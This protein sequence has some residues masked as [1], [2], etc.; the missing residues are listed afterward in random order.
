MKEFGDDYWI[1]LGQRAV[2]CEGW[3]WMPGMRA[4]HSYTGGVRVLATDDGE[5]SEEYVVLPD[6]G[7]NCVMRPFDWAVVGCFARK[8]GNEP[9][10]PDLRDPAT[11]GCLLALVR[12]AWGHE[13]EIEC[14]WYDGHLYRVVG[15]CPNGNARLD[16]WS[17]N[18]ADE[19][20]RHRAGV[21]VQAL[22]S[23]PS[24][25]AK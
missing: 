19:D 4:T 15:Y 22:E 9:F 1:E 3:R 12:E 10:V 21:L 8:Y 25:E 14:D 16:Y 2:A 23:A 17:V 24:K 18:G 7:G 5:I 13:L 6:D 11:V 20:C